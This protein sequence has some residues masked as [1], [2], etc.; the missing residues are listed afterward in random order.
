MSFLL[1]DCFTSLSAARLYSTKRQDDRLV[2]NLNGCGDRDCRLIEIRYYPGI[3]RNR[4]R[5]TTT[6]YLQGH[7]SSGQDSKRVHPSKSLM[8]YRYSNPPLSMNIVPLNVRPSNCRWPVPSIINR[9]TSAVKWL[10]NEQVNCSQ[11]FVSPLK[12]DVWSIAG[13]QSISSGK[14]YEITFLEMLPP[15]YREYLNWPRALFRV[16]TIQL[17]IT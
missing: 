8:R 7:R 11:L 16:L 14:K 17:C 4:L 5:K 12:P 10:R 2:M 6:K 13:R 15:A 3:C 1:V 9:P